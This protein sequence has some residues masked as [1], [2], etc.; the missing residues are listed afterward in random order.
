M[1]NV[2]YGWPVALGVAGVAVI[3][4][5]VIVIVVVVVVDVGRRVCDSCGSGTEKT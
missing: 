4:V 3:V 1:M 2:Y 5:V